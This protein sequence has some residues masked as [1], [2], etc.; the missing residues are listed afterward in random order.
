MGV[1]AGH[2]GRL[3][4]VGKRDTTLDESTADDPAS[5]RQLNR[6]VPRV[7][8]S[9]IDDYPL[10]NLSM[11]RLSDG[12]HA[13]KQKCVSLPH[14]RFAGLTMLPDATRAKGRLNGAPTK[15]RFLA[16]LGMTKRRED[17]DSKRD[18]DVAMPN[19]RVSGGWLRR[20][21]VSHFPQTTR[22]DGAPFF[23]V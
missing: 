22:K 13:V 4:R 21:L 8:L 3:Y 23:S 14:T 19:S 7:R 20:F 12:R 16:L 11:I 9:K 15:S 10:D 17:R 1:T 5:S 18:R 6:A 2:P